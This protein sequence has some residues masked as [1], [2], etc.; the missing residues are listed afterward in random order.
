VIEIKDRAAQERMRRAGRA[1]GALLSALREKVRPGVTTRELDRLAEAVVA[2]LGGIPAFKGY[3]G[4]PATICASA[5]DVV[6]HGIPGDKPLDEGDILGLDVGVI[7]DGYYGDTAAT[8]PVGRADGE[9]MRLIRVTRESLER[10]IAALRPGCRLGVVGH[11]VQ[12]HAED[13][14]FSVVRDFVGHGIGRRLHEDPRIP[15]YGSPESGVEV[16]EG[17]TLAIEPMLNAGGPEVKIDADGW[18]A[19][20]LDGSVS[21]HFE[22]TVLVTE[23]GAEVLTRDDG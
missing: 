22:H 10:G 5:N 4:Y 16:K 7:V 11:A 23:A 2:K 6:V 1:A 14:G 12:T 17:M 8:V 15:N 20:T 13:Q 3:R 9:R 19:R 18:T 21:A